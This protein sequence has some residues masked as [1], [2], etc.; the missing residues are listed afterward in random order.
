MRIVEETLRPG[1]KLTEV[2]QRSD[3]SRS[4]IFG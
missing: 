1:A 2:A 3:V 4:L